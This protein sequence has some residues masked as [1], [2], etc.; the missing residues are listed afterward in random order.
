MNFKYVVAIVRP[1]LA[2][3]LEE[4]LSAVGV[5]GITL[6]KVKGFGD[7]KNFFSRDWLSE[8]TK[9]EIFT[10]ESKVDALLDV[11]QESAEA[12]VSGVGV[13]AVMPVD[14]FLHLH[15]R[16]QDHSRLADAVA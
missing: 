8:Y 2:A 5:G 14:R 16:H 12:D 4:K 13:V 9:V 15:R 6:S 3:P 1:E 10:E 11:L 7:Y